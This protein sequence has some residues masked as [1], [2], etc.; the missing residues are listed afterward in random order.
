MMSIRATQLGAGPE[1]SN[2]SV[3]RAELAAA[4]VGSVARQADPKRR[5]DRVGVVVP[6][7]N[8]QNALPT[9]LDGL[10]AAA[11]WMSVPITVVVVLDSCTDRSAETVAV[12]SRTSGIAIDTVTVDARNVGLA[13]RAGI[14]ELLRRH[15]TPGLWLATTDADSIVPENWFTA[16]LNHAAAGAHVVAGTVTVSDWQDHSHVVRDRAVKDYLAAPH[17]HV[18]GANLSFTA[19]A[20]EAAGGFPPIASAEDVALVE[21]FRRNDEPIAWAIDL[22]VTTS[23]RRLARAPRGFAGYLSGLAGPAEEALESR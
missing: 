19:A 10:K 9:C 16:Q 2:A 18:H 15:P 12:A 5:I 4:A 22:A 7:N 17:R 8:E 14:A 20:Y 6:A 1:R 13:R 11:R 3:L 23:A 21:A